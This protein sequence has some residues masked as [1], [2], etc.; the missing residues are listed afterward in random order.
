MRRGEV[1]WYQFPKPD[2]RR[3]VL[4]LTRDFIIP[5]LSEVSVAPITTTIR[6][7][8][9]EVHLTRSD[10]MPRA[11]AINL[12]HIQTIPKAKVGSLITTISDRKL[13][14]VRPALLFALGFHAD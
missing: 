5:H 2:K 1:R 9:T 3:P 11:C 13:R 14:E 10:G 8:P 7:I 6:N 12:D 4:I